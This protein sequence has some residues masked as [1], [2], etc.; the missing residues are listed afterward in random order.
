MRI[1]KRVLSLLCVGALLLSMVGTAGA[2]AS[3]EPYTL[4]EEN[5]TFEENSTGVTL[6]TVKAEVVDAY[7]NI[8]VPQALDN[9]AVTALG[10]GSQVFLGSCWYLNSVT[11]P[12]GLTTIAA[13]AFDD[14]NDMTGVVL[15]DSLAT[16]GAK[17]FQYCWKLTD[18][19]LPEGLTYIG[20]YAFDDTA[21]TELRLPGGITFVGIGAFSGTDLTALDAESFGGLTALPDYMF[22]ECEQLKSVV[23]PDEIT[24][25]GEN[26]FDDC[27]ALASVTL[28]S[29]I[30]ELPDHIFDG[31]TAL[32]TVEL[33]DSIAG[34]GEYAFSGCQMLDGITLPGGLTSLG[35]S[36][37]S[38]CWALSD[39]EIPGGVE[40]L[41]T[42]TFRMCRELTDVTLNEGL[43]AIDLYAFSDCHKLPAITFPSTLT[44]INRLAFFDGTPKLREATF[45]GS[46]PAF[47]ENANY[48]IS[49]AGMTVY[50]PDNNDSY[51][52][53]KAD[54]DLKAVLKPISEKPELPG[55]TKPTQIKLT[56]ELCRMPQK[57]MV[58]WLT[59]AV[60]YEPNSALLPTGRIDTYFQVGDGAPVKQAPAVH[61]TTGGDTYHKT[62]GYDVTELAEQGATLK[63]YVVQQPSTGYAASTSVTLTG[64]VENYSDQNYHAFGVDSS[65]PSTATEYGWQLDGEGTG[66][67]IVSAPTAE[68]SNSNL[69]ALPN[70]LNGL[71]VTGLGAGLFSGAPLSRVSIP[72]TVTEI[73][74]NAFQDC[75][76]LYSVTL[77]AVVKS[78]GVDAFKGSGLTSVTMLGSA[79]DLAENNNPFPADAALHTPAGDTSY[80]IPPWRE[81]KREPAELMVDFPAITSESF[82][83]G[84]VGKMELLLPVTLEAKEYPGENAPAPDLGKLE[85]WLG[86]SRLVPT[87]PVNESTLHIPI[88]GAAF[89]LSASLKVK[90]SGDANYASASKTM[91]I[92]IPIQKLPVAITGVTA[93]I[94]TDGGKYA[95]WLTPAFDPA[96]YYG[97]QNTAPKLDDTTV[98][99][100]GKVLIPT[101]HQAQGTVS[102]PVEDAM[103]GKTLPVVVNYKGDTRFEPTQS[104][105][106]S[107]TLPGAPPKTSLTAT[108]GAVLKS[109]ES[110]VLPLTVTLAVE[111]GE[112]GDPDRTK[113]EVTLGDS[114]ASYT[115][116]AGN[117][118]NVAVPEALLGARVKVTVSYP[119]EGKYPAARAELP[120]VL[121]SDPHP[122]KA[123]TALSATAGAVVWYFA[124]STPTTST[125]GLPLTPTLTHN[126]YTGDRSLTP[127]RADVTVT[128]GGVLVTSDA[129]RWVS[130][131]LYVDIPAAKINTTAT[132]VLTYPGDDHFNP[133]SK[134]ISNVSL[135]F[136]T[137]TPPPTGDGGGGGGGTAPA[138]KPEAGSDAKVTVSDK[139]VTEA[140]KAAAESGSVVLKADAPAN[141]KS[142]AVTVP[143]SVMKAVAK[144]EAPVSLQT[145]V[146]DLKL[147]VKVLET[148][149]ANGAKDVVLSA[150]AADSAALPKAAQEAL[151]GRP[152]YDISITAGGKSVSQFGGGTVTVAL[153]YTPAPGEDASALVA[154]WV[155]EDGSTEILRN[156]SYKDGKLTF[157]TPHL[158]TYAI[159]HKDISFVDVAGDNWAKADIGFAASRGILNGMGDNLFGPGI[160]L[161]GSMAVAAL[162]RMDGVQDGAPGADWAAPALAWAEEKGLL[163][164]DF[165]SDAM[166]TR[167]QFAY[168]VAGVMGGTEK[169]DGPGYVDVTRISLLYLDSVNY[170]TSMGIMQGTGDGYFSP[171]SFLT[172][173]ELAAVLHRLVD[174]QIG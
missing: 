61:G 163:P 155:K 92:T 72:A 148:L 47:S 157:S 125:Y 135:A 162:A 17:A 127:N 44:S 60:T 62:F 121:L 170:L 106:V 89:G 85:V 86:S 14:C 145:P 159:V 71:P 58:L 136:G 94:K 6:L 137:P 114:E 42:F 142:V 41:Q 8:V 65:D 29:N 40:Q 63:V 102:V 96:D 55:D 154:C 16:I 28:P 49:T 21:L 172:R 1:G 4:K 34:I 158:S 39:I 160:A 74:A 130:N 27:T 70:S 167:E 31:C 156:S 168:L 32:E 108:A 118:L 3:P 161:T 143:A 80:N 97:Q 166:M 37:F 95:L 48:F 19:T 53:W 82:K 25:L 98:T 133:S 174:W 116:G 152:V 64:K 126:P 88:P 150:G 110:Y 79:P 91:D 107:V 20:D 100:G 33:P 57:N 38:G 84:T 119:G 67:V 165:N 105:P 35:Q 140:V 111:N 129:L 128:M 23:F 171:Q 149:Q 68:L 30:T 151:A 103:L 15:P 131:T 56:A 141:A 164:K 22:S 138:P 83:L 78:L 77:P 43:K 45:R 117:V 87:L 11:L 90:Y 134:T 139:A 54:P 50:Y 112:A 173:S 104:A 122:E 76:M 75:G 46:A 93:E 169:V 81:M 113:L 2:A 51:D 9:K 115:A 66:V 26:L 18:V 132:F 24:T 5:C 146:A 13:N 153:P 144:A 52:A 120:S 109:G 59:T 124:T 7:A 123:D 36:A 101:A 12:E 69:V 73:G 99:I 10:N 147:D